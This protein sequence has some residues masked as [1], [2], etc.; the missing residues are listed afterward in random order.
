MAHP[1]LEVRRRFDGR[2]GYCGVSESDTGGLLTVDHFLPLSAGGDDSDA[3]LIYACFRCNTYKGDW[4]ASDNDLRQDHRLLHPLLDSVAQHLREVPESGHLEPSTPRGRF[5]IALLRLNRPELVEYR[6]QH[7]LR[8]LFLET[9]ELVRDENRLL[10]L[11]VANLER[12]LEQL[13]R[14][15][16]S[17]QES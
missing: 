16:Q 7:R 3:N 4:H 13:R 2:C 9:L 15:Y 10:K 5:H 12:Y 11:R 1:R 8:Q 17:E 6:L 14:R